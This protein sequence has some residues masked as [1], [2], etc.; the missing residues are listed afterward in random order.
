MNIYENYQNFSDPN[1][2]RNFN[3]SLKDKSVLGRAWAGLTNPMTA[4]S[5]A[6]L[7]A[8]EAMGFDPTG[9]LAKQAEAKRAAEENAANRSVPSTMT[10]GAPS[11]DSFSITVP[12]ATDKTPLQ[13]GPANTSPSMAVP[14]KPAASAPATAAPVKPAGYQPPT[15]EEMAR[16]RRETGTAFSSQSINDKLSLERMRAGEETF[17]TKQANAYRKANPNYRPGQYVKG[18]KP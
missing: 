5:G 15:A 8:Q 12:K 6:S 11:T 3:D 16:F 14:S 13:I 2:I 9:Q 1:R 7:A 4:I 10:V 18:Y 17:D